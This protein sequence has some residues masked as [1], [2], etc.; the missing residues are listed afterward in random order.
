[1]VQ[2]VESR[3]PVRQELSRLATLDEPP[4]L[5][6][7]NAVEAANVRVPV[8]HGDDGA[9]GELGVDDALHECFGVAVHALDRETLMG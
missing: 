4:V 3:A 1:M 7:S 8:C 5:K 2:R 6:H 9:V